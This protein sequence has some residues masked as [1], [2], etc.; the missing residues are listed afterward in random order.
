MPHVRV[1]PALLLACAAL[2]TAADVDLDVIAKETE[3][4]CAASAADKATP[5]LLMAKT[6][7]AAALLE[8]EGD[9]AFAKFR[10][11]DSTFV[12]CGTY[13]SVYDAN[14]VVLFQPIKYKLVGKLL[15]G[16]CDVGGK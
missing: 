2:A 10:G 4:A 3:T 8:Q 7:E 1:L 16:L 11:K 9:A 14:G 6:R 12:F 5:E 13:V 15:V